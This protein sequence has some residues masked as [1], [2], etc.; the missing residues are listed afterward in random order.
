[1]RPC[2]MG[3][4]IP[5]HSEMLRAVGFSWWPDNALEFVRRYIAVAAGSEPK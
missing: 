2:G 3:F 4:P 1:M 5:E